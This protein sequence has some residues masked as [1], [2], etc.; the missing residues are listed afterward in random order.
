MPAHEADNGVIGDAKPCAAFQPADDRSDHLRPNARHHAIQG[1]DGQVRSHGQKCCIQRYEFR[2]RLRGTSQQRPGKAGIVVDLDENVRQLRRAVI[3][4]ERAAAMFDGG[5][6]WRALAARQMHT[7][8][9]DSH[10]TI[11]NRSGQSRHAGFQDLLQALDI[12]LGIVRDREVTQVT[13]AVPAPECRRDEPRL[14]GLMHQA[15]FRGDG[16]VVQRRFSS[17]AVAA[18]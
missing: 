11:C 13:L 9:V 15:V 1:S 7:V 3:D 4:C 14:H 6:F 8:C 10:L 17:I 2:L 18:V 16:T 12:K 5:I